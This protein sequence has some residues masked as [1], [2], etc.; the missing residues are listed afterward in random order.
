MEPMTQEYVTEIGDEHKL[1]TEIDEL[2]DGIDFQQSMSQEESPRCIPSTF[3]EENG[4]NSVG[5]FFIGC[6]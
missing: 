6:T 5:R 1:N 4:L 2:L 3:P